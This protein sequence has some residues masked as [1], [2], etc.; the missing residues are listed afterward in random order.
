MTVNRRSLISGALGGAA[1]VVVGRELGPTSAGAAADV[2]RTEFEALIERVAY[3]EQFHPPMPTVKFSGSV[4]LP[5]GFVVPFGE[6]WDFDP[7]VSTTVEVGA[8]VVVAGTLQMRP[9]NPG[10]V[11]TLR[12][13]GVDESAMIGGG[14]EPLET[15]V[16]LW[17]VGA[18]VVDAAGATRTAWSR[19]TSALAA[20]AT[21]ITLPAAPAGWRVGDELVVTPTASHSVTNPHDRYSYAT[22]QAVDGATVTVSALQNAHPLVDVGGG[23]MFGAEVLNLTRNVVI[24]GTATGRSHTFWNSSAPQSVSNVALRH[25]GPRKPSAAGSQSWTEPVAGRYPMHFHM[26][27]DGSRGSVIDGVVA[28]GCSRA[29]AVHVSHG[30]TLNACIAHDIWDEPFWW[31]GAPAGV[32]ADPTHDAVWSRCVASRVKYD[33]AHR[34]FRLSGFTLGQGDNN[35][36]VDCVAVGVQGN[37]DAAGFVWP[38]SS[39]SPWTFARN[40]AHNNKRHG[41]F[42]WQNGNKVHV[43]E[44][45]A[46]YNNGGSGISHGAYQSGYLYRNGFL[47]ANK[48]SALA[49]HAACH[50][51]PVPPLRF[52]TIRSDAVGLHANPI[53]L[54][55]H[56]LPSGQAVKVYGCEFVGHTG[57]VVGCV[58]ATAGQPEWLDLVEVSPAATVKW[59]ALSHAASAVR[60]QN[61][62]SAT[63]FTPAGASAIAPFATWTA[64]APSPFVADLP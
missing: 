36:V 27:G 3:L 41:L 10:V 56:T 45:F 17:I 4:S 23:F 47:Y 13:V 61:G 34:G 43:V 29:F 14:M 63:L 42:V 25:M 64:S 53:R 1:G 59:N 38:E 26:A 62:A 15:D 8:N 37:G 5:A 40:V 50:T 46:C 57:T 6:V 31:D 18:G 33:P 20:G 24:E 12:F 52:E 28:V 30:V 9:A 11:H 44:D 55:K 51:A 54:E 48:L 22:V 19:T 2:D 7:D 16:G 49:I 32:P 35:T 58:S 39:N 60:V 21:S